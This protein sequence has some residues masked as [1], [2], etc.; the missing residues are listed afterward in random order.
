MKKLLVVCKKDVLHYF[1]TPLG[2]IFIAAVLLIG[3]IY[4]YM[5]NFYF[6]EASFGASINS[7]PFFFVFLIPILAAGSFTEERR[8]KTEQLLFALPLTSKQIVFGKYFAL[9]SVLAVPLAIMAFY[10]LLMA[11]YGQVN[12]SQAYA[13]LF[14]VFLLGMALTSICMFI[15]SLS[16]SMA[17]SAI[18]CFAVMFVLYQMNNFSESFSQS[19]SRAFVGFILLAVFYG[20]FVWWLTKNVFVAVIPSISIVIILTVIRYISQYAMSGKLNLI[21]SGMAVFQRLENFKAGIFDL[22]AVIYYLSITLLFA[23]FT[24]YAF[25]QRRWER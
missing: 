22:Y 7:V 3:G 16:G 4:V 14:A 5:N 23:L 12:F 9:L 24:V 21:M 2:Y 6:G 10:P 19:A 15:S 20:V 1:S 17:I 13:N 25:E 8:Q 11:R 18:I